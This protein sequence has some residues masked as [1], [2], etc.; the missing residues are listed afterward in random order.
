MIISDLKG[1]D[2]LLAADELPPLYEQVIVVGTVS[3]INVLPQ[4]WQARRFP[5]MSGTMETEFSDSM[6]LTPCDAVVE[7][8]VYWTPMTEIPG[9]YGVGK[10]VEPSPPRFARRHRLDT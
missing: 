8:V 2:W 10:P 7:G 3:K 4:A 5:L 1:L 9:R 6:W